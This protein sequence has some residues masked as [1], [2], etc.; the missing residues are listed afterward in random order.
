VSTDAQ[1]PGSSRAVAAGASGGAA[2]ALELAP[3][4]TVTLHDDLPL[5]VHGAR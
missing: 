4:V 5:M 2:P 3:G 1:Q